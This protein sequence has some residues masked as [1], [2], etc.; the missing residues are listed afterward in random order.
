MKIKHWSGGG[1]SGI[2]FFCIGC[3]DLH[4]ITTDGSRGWSWN[5]DENQP[6]IT[7]SVLVTRPAVSDAGE[8]FEEFLK[9]QICHTFV[10]CNGAQP[11]EIVYLSD[12]S[13]SLAGS[14]HLLQD[15]PERFL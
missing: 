15:I 3:N 8:G 11:G 9:A 13:H 10:G 2:H 6:V 5:G 7:P 12:C 4:T 14:V 1:R